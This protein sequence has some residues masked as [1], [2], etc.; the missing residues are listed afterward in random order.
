M[1]AENQ[2]KGK[3]R[4]A[5]SC[6]LQGRGC[7]REGYF[8]LGGTDLQSRAGGGGFSELLVLLSLGTGKEQIPQALGLSRDCDRLRS[9]LVLCGVAAGLLDG[10]PSQ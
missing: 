8:T 9:P 5:S 3:L 6:L 7:Y 1:L 2:E 10:C 4:R